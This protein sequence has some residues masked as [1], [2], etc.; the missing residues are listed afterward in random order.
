MLR[1][2]NAAI[3][4]ARTGNVKA[5]SL[6]I[7]FLTGSL[8]ATPQLP[9]PTGHGLV[10]LANGQMAGWGANDF[11]QLATGQAVFL[12]APLRLNLPGARLVAV[13]AGSRHSLALDDTGKVWAWGD[14]SSGQLGLGHTRPVTGPTL[15]TGLPGR[16]LLVAAG[17]QH[18]A[19]LLAG[20]S[21]WVWGSNNRGQMASGKTDAF[22]V[23]AQPVRVAAMGPVFDLAVGDDF[24]L[25]LVENKASDTAG[26]PEKNGEKKAAV[27]RAVWIWGAGSA[28]P[29]AVD[30][31]SGAVVV[32]AAGDVAMA[33]TATGG[34]WRWRPEQTAPAFA[35]REAFDRL[36][37]MTHPMLAALRAQ[38][39]AE[40]QTKTAAESVSATL[41]SGGAT[42]ASSGTA[43]AAPGRPVAPLPVPTALAAPA[44]PPA[45]TVVQA[46]VAAAPMTAPAS[47]AAPVVSAPVSAPVTAAAS[48][49]SS[50]ALIRVS[51]SGTVRLSSGFGGDGAASAGTPMENVQVNAEGAQCSVTDGQ[52]RYTC[53]LPAGWSGRLS[54]RRNNYRFSPSA[55]SFQNLRADAGQQDF[56]AIYDPR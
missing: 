27:K 36:G 23:Q 54:L 28:A 34:Y 15:V 51:L 48:V 43:A 21:V 38:I 55:L 7:F 53:L 4:C 42:N 29:R 49:A 31:I 25:A 19:A 9:P 20:G 11:A 12:P 5:A 47:V 18:S 10:L 52:G 44:A 14:N 13:T 56:A 26:K 3:A 39:A 35:Q 30:G 22:A 40:M 41:A 46:A 17:A 33:R 32:R 2:L 45:V 50:A 6:L 1:F 16:A 8:A 37:E 24:V